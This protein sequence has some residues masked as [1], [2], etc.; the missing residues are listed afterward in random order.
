MRVFMQVMSNQEVY[1]CIEC[2]QDAQEAS[3]KLISEAL[4]LGSKDDISCIVVIFH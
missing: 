1:H 2:L 3:E 4:E